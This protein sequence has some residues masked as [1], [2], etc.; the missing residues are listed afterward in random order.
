MR[1]RASDATGL[2]WARSRCRSRS[3]LR[4]GAG[5]A[6]R[7]FSASSCSTGS[8][9]SSGLAGTPALRRGREPAR[10]PGP[11]AHGSVRRGGFASARSIGEPREGRQPS[12]RWL[13]LLLRHRS[14][15]C[16]LVGLR[17]CAIV[18][19]DWSARDRRR[20][21][22][23]ALLLEKDDAGFRA[24]V[25]GVDEAGLPEGDV[26]VARR[27]LDAQ[28]QGR[29][30]DHRT[31]ARSCAAG[32]WSPAS[33]APGRCSRRAIRRGRPGDGSSTT[34]GASARRAGVAWASARG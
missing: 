26:T 27:V 18:V 2:P 10:R 21:M 1:G 9:A 15:G 24:A 31:R 29:A 5:C 6:S 11:R 20:T 3:S 23:K 33:T 19:A 8:V 14:A 25:R 4:R 17:R 12:K 16:A 22:F 28:L 32:R 13:T 30:R 34:A 7:P